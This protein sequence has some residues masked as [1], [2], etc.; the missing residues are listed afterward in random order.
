MKK[1]I[2]LTA[3]LYISVCLAEGQT[4]EKHDKSEQI[5]ESWEEI[6]EEK[7]KNAYYLN[8]DWASFDLFLKAGCRVEGQLM[9]LNL[10]TNN[11]EVKFGTKIKVLSADKVEYFEYNDNGIIRLFESMQ[12]YNMDEGPKY[13]FLEVLVSGDPGLLQK[14]SLERQKK[15]R[16]QSEANQKKKAKLVKSSRYFLHLEG[17]FVEISQEKRKFLLSFGEHQKIVTCYLKTHKPDIKDRE[18]L[19]KLIIFLKTEV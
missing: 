7:T 6:G 14:I 5:I 1:L 2:L 16:K 15:P 8:S 12:G 4:P 3:F 11:F 19:K 10:L 18:D 17:E 9:R 13:G